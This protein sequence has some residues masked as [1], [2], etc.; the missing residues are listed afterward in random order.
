[1]GI[2]AKFYYCR[3]GGRTHVFQA[4]KYTAFIEHAGLEKGLLD[5][6]YRSPKTYVR[7]QHMDKWLAHQVIKRME[8]K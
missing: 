6:G 3:E 8:G 5:S 7:E 4:S 2:G 1:M